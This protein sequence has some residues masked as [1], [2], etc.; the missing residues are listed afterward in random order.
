MARNRRTAA[1]SPPVENW[2]IYRPAIWVAMLGVAVALLVAPA[3]L[4]AVPFGVA[5]G[6]VLKIQ[7][8]K[9]QR[10]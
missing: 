3:Y 7:I 9:R 4:S 10:R 5:L 6:M 1:S 2:K 8:R